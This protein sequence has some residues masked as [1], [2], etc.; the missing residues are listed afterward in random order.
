MGLEILLTENV[1]LVDLYCWRGDW[2]AGFAVIRGGTGQPL[3]VTDKLTI[4]TPDV[5]IY[6]NLPLNLCHN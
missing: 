2:F 5:G 3:Q 6:N 1:C 4:I